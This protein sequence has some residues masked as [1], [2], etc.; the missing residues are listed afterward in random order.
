MKIIHQKGYST[1]ELLSWKL[2]V[3]KNIIESIQALITAV[4]KFDYKYEALE[5]EVCFL[6]FFKQHVNDK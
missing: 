6:I 3:Y 4:E 5:D 1:D 2:T